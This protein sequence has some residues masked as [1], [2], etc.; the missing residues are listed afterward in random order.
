MG[1]LKYNNDAI[2]EENLFIGNY[3]E[4]DPA[5]GGFLS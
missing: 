4:P 3:Q 5:R 2:R 1:G